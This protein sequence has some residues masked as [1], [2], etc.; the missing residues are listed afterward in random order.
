MRSNT[1]SRHPDIGPF[2]IRRPP[3]VRWFAYLD[4]A[5]VNA[6]RSDLSESGLVSDRT[7]LA[8]VAGLRS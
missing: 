7:R 4:I 3:F 8:K 5:A 2:G 6:V 1:A